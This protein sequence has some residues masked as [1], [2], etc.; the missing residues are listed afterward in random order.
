MAT[1]KRAVF[2]LLVEDQP[3]H[4]E[5]I[6]R[7]LETDEGRFAVTIAASLREAKAQLK[8]SLPDVVLTDYKLPDGFGLEL[9]SDAKPRCPVIVL[10]SQGD[11]HVAV[12][13]LKAGA[14]DYLV[15]TDLAR[16]DMGRVLESAV[17]EW[18]HRKAQE[19]A[20]NEIL[21]LGS[22][23]QAIL[24]AATGLALMATDLEGNIT[25]FN[26]GAENLLGYRA[27]EVVGILR[28]DVFHV[29]ED[30][31]QWRNLS[32]DAE[33]AFLSYVGALNEAGRREWILLAKNGSELW[34]EITTTPVVIQESIT[35]YLITGTN[36]T[37][38]KREESTRRLLEQRLSQAH[39]M[40]SLGQLAGGIAHD[41]N[42]LLACVLGYASL[43]VDSG[44]QSVD[45]LRQYLTEI[46]RAGERGR[47]FVS[48][49]LAFSRGE[50][51]EPVAV[52]VGAAA[53]EAMSLLRSALPSGMTAELEVEP[54][55]P[56]ALFTTTQLHQLLINL[57]I[58]A[59]DAMQ[60]EGQL[61]VS[62][63]G[64]DIQATQA[65]TCDSCHDSFSGRYIKIVVVDDGPGFGA[66]T[67]ARLFEPFFTTKVRGKG[68]GMG[69][70]VVHGTLHQ[71]QGH[72]TVTSRL[73][74]GSEFT[75]YLPV[76]TGVSKPVSSLTPQRTD[77]GHGR[78]IL[79]VDDE[80]AV[81]RV[82]EE[83]LRRVASE[84][85]VVTSSVRALELFSADPMAFD[86][87]VTDQTMP[88]MSGTD[89]C[90]KM[91]ELN[92]NLP[93]ILCSGYSETVDAGS[94]ASFGIKRF[95]MKPV[96]AA[97]LTSE[98]ARLLAL[99]QG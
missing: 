72:I 9:L 57:S 24:D 51:I 89:M 62:V 76:H 42:N 10:T 99:A 14:W 60:N 1:E 77:G 46:Q 12:E 34:V 5:L 54:G 65:L 17:R 38:R 30:R 41:F 96:H 7:S 37:Q 84:V 82:F 73:A 55:L 90:K 31:L 67:H 85:T 8:T 70:S 59:R 26:A 75:L 43:A 80:P 64:A 78:R 53:A 50:S 88:E 49:L 4:V 94:V 95:L 21:A 91:L 58:N 56:C 6:E 16:L 27:E 69:L 32:D 74:E 79:V 92:P 11:E 15:K 86:L 35:G 81:A 19:L 18:Q 33:Q 22:R 61:K 97:T 47:D 93:I 66:Q 71:N 36:V 29:A 25:T 45:T 28:P 87:V 2:V 13:A 52:D 40:E 44:E 83:V 98:A 23:L 20:Q 3:A 68:T 63:S 48:Q 39:K